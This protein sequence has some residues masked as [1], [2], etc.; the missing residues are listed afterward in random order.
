MCVS[1]GA[2]TTGLT[3]S[4]FFEA[5]AGGPL[6]SR[7]AKLGFRRLARFGGTLTLFSLTD[8]MVTGSGL[9]TECS[10]AGFFARIGLRSALMVETGSA[11]R[12]TGS[13]VDA[14]GFFSRA[15]MPAVEDAAE[16]RTAGSVA[17][18]KG[19]SVAKL[20]GFSAAKIEGFSAAK[21]EGFSAAKI[22]GF[23]GAGLRTSACR[24]SASGTR[25][26]L[27]AGTGGPRL[28][29]ALRFAS[30]SGVEM[31]SFGFPG[32]LLGTA[33]LAF[34][35]SF[36]CRML[37]LNSSTRSL[38]AGPPVM[39]SA[40]LPRMMLSLNT[41]GATYFSVCVCRSLPRALLNSGSAARSPSDGRDLDLRLARKSIFPGAVW[42]LGATAGGELRVLGV[43]LGSGARGAGFG[44]SSGRAAGVCG[45]FMSGNSAAGGS[46]RF[47]FAF[48]RSAIQEG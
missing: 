48:A 29:S 16:L 34:I 28:F 42:A 8:G 24:A 47:C 4:F 5:A 45:D 37:C 38:F 14:N 46:L 7:F 12:T 22:E 32:G 27:A 23:S 44:A 18:L 20:E 39:L 10:T 19:F 9:G 21:I 25:S 26:T 30:P 3:G 40:D 41:F 36:C 13:G 17:K 11:M 35:V 33:L 31:G 15:R 43:I 1:C 2:S 6:A